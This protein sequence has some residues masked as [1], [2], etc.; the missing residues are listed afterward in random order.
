M[1]SPNHDFANKDPANIFL[2]QIKI[3][4][5]EFERLSNNIRV[6]SRMRERIRAGAGHIV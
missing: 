4:F 2:E 6:N 3:G 1:S 5:A